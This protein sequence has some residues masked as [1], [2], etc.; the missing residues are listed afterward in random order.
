[1]AALSIPPIPCIPPLPDP[2]RALKL[3]F[4][5][6]MIRLHEPTKAALAVFPDEPGR[7]LQ[8]VNSWPHDDLVVEEMQR[9]MEE[10]GPDA[11]LPTK[12]AIL[13]DIKRRADETRDPKDYVALMQLYAQMRD[14]I[15]KAG[16][17]EVN[18]KVTSNV[19]VVPSQGSDDEW[20]KRAMRS[21]R[22]LVDGAAS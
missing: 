11:F 8:I 19:L 6:A 10:S 20:E 21:Q 17:S 16:A 1:M 15:P 22:R 5:A 18:V 7:A 14:F 13:V 2:L 3:R 12:Q 9:L 4:A